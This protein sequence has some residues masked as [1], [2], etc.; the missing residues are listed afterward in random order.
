MRERF[1]GWTK[2]PPPSED[3]QEAIGVGSTPLIL[4]CKWN[5]QDA[6]HYDPFMFDRTDIIRALIAAGA[7][8]RARERN[9]S[10]ALVHALQTR[11]AILSRDPTRR[12][13]VP[14]ELLEAALPKAD[15]VISILRDSGAED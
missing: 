12:P 3:S 4:A 14:R 8:V 11:D 10:T 6:R 9:G 15:E 13:L 5:T 1:P 7:D 2:E